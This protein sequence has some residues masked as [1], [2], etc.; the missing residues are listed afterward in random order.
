[1]KQ[2][3]QRHNPEYRQLDFHRREELKS[4]KMF[5]LLSVFFFKSCWLESCKQK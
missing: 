5:D 1:V 2:T 3:K 4:Y